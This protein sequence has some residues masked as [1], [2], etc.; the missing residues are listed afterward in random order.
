MTH[1]QHSIRC[2][3]ICRRHK[4]HVLLV[5]HVND[6][7]GWSPTAIAQLLIWD[8]QSQIDWIAISGIDRRKI[9]KIK[10]ANN[11]HLS[12]LSHL[13]HGESTSQGFQS[14]VNRFASIRHHRFRHFGSLRFTSVHFPSLIHLDSPWFTSLFNFFKQ[15]SPGRLRSAPTGR[16]TRPCLCSSR[17]PPY[18]GH[19]RYTKF[20]S[21]MFRKC[22]IKHTTKM[23]YHV[24]TFIFDTQ[25]PHS[26]IPI[27][28]RC[29]WYHH[30]S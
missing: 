22:W 23:S 20:G 14:S 13:S 15:L 17:Q 24:T 16:W 5:G 29:F 21:N 30:L 8:W 4:L 3:P 12:H 28:C 26:C 2:H 9:V 11:G 6:C 27:N 18:T 25:Q 7:K 10:Q 1:K 19:T